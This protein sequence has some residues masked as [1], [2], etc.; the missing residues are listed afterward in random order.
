M[1]TWHFSPLLLKLLEIRDGLRV[2]TVADDLLGTAWLTVG[3]K[4][5]SAVL[6]QIANRPKVRRMGGPCNT[7]G[8]ENA[9]VPTEILNGKYHLEA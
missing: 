2:C 5:F 6:R 1:Q 8:D 9:T 7:Y 4:W 3:K